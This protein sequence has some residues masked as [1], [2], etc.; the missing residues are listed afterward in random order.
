MKGGNI[1]INPKIKKVL[2]FTFIV[3]FLGFSIYPSITG[4]Y[5]DNNF[6]MN[7]LTYNNQYNQSMLINENDTI[8]DVAGDV[9]D[10]ETYDYVH[11][12]PNVDVKNIDVSRLDYNR[13]EKDV[14]LSLKV[15]GIIEDRGSFEEWENDSWD[16]IIDIDSVLYILTLTTSYETYSITYINQSCKIRYHSTDE[17]ANISK[18]DFY[19]SGNTLNVTFNLNN[20]GEEYEEISVDAIYYRILWDMENPPEE[21][22]GLVDEAP[23]IPLQGYSNVPYWGMVGQDIEFHGYAVWGYPPYSY[24]WDFGDGKNSTDRNPIHIYKKGGKYEYIFTITDNFGI[25]ISDNGSIEIEKRSFVIGVIDD[26]IVDD[27]YSYLNATNVWSF[28]FS[29]SSI[30]HFKSEQLMIYNKYVGFVTR[31]F[32]FGLFTIFSPF[33]SKYIIDIQSQDNVSN[34]VVW[35]VLEIEGKPIAIKDVELVLLNESGEIQNNAEI[36]FDDRYSIGEINPFDIF[37]VTA[38]EDGYFVFMIKHKSTGATIFKS[39]L[40]RY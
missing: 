10:L 17:V 19:T 18:D 29:T 24:Y 36:I 11:F 26:K 14:F 22:V 21:R 7:T 30:N 27:N 31:H 20:S 38:P 40:N 12:H 28:S 3:I 35:R 4:S 25:S 13:Y 34:T 8:L 1:M 9:R 2:S 37:I 39:T 5:Y 32:I 33:P 6:N 23:D 15:W 16:E